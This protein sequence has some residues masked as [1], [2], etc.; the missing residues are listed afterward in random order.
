[1]PWAPRFYCRNG[2]IFTS[3]LGA[4]KRVETF[5]S[6]VAEGGTCGVSVG[7]L[8]PEVA[9]M[10][11]KKLDMTNFDALKDEWNTAKML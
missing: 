8:P 5:L 10:V 2:C 4:K 9:R 11:A 6:Y 3:V 1:L 7:T